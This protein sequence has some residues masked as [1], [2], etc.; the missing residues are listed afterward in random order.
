MRDKVSRYIYVWML[1][2]GAEVPPRPANPRSAVYWYSHGPCIWS[3]K[4]NI[5]HKLMVSPNSAPDTR[6][7]TKMTELSTA[8]IG[9]GEAL[10]QIRAEMLERS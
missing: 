4:Y 7:R 8:G 6:Y 9:Y 10:M 3:D 5:M 1:G 2:Y